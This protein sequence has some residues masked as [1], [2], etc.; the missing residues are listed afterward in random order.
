MKGIF[1]LAILQLLMTASS[2]QQR[3][4]T[5]TG[6]ISFYSDAP[7]EKIEAVNKNVSC[8]LDAK[9][10]QLQFVVLIKGFEFRKAL[11]QEHFNE[12]YLES[13]KF[14]KAGFKGQIT[15]NGSINYSTDG[16]YEAVVKGMLSIHGQEKLIE[17][18]GT[19]VVAGGKV[20]ASA[21]FPASVKDYN[22]S[23]PAIMK[24]KIAR[25]VQ[26]TVSCLLTPL[27]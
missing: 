12:N 5:K 9:T 24:D 1:I 27:Q 7:M 3:F 2:A 13:D 17:T 23:I 14:P 18:K 6:K 20:T 25:E 22:I 8:V 21:V 15:N 10:G 26:I 16:N 19:I 4:F 11:M